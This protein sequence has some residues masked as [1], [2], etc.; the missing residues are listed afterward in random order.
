MRLRI[1]GDRDAMH[2][3]DDTAFIVLVKGMLITGVFQLFLDLLKR[4][5]A[6]IEDDVSVSLSNWHKRSCAS[7]GTK[8]SQPPTAVAKDSV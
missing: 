7:A 1:Y 3:D 2:V 4:R 8:A 6:Q 5:L